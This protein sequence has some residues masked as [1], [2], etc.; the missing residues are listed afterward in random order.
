MRNALKVLALIAVSLLVVSCKEEGSIS[1]HSL[2]FEGV[3]AV[4]ESRL[5][6][7][8]ATRQSAK[9]PWGRKRFF[10]RARF[11]EDLQRLQAFYA[12]RGYPDARV[13]A[14][15]VDLN[16]KQDAVDILVTIEEGDPVLIA[17]INFVGF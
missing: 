1:V 3:A 15:K 16:D 12:D 4:D 11:D 8:L 5:R 17:A 9:L 2:K 13:T 7:A 6:D 10:D 14:F